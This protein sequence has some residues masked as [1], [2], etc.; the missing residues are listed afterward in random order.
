MFLDI[1]MW[2]NWANC[3][4]ERKSKCNWKLIR[5]LYRL[6]AEI[7]WRTIPHTYTR[8]NSIWQIIAIFFALVAD[9]WATVFRGIMNCEK[10]R[11]KQYKEPH[12]KKVN[13]KHSR[14]ELSDILYLNV[15]NGFAPSIHQKIQ[16]CHSCESMKYTESHIFHGLFWF[17]IKNNFELPLVASRAC[18]CHYSR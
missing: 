13:K 3:L 8:S 14:R 1:P 17:L 18:H 10:R 2:I 11:K 7:S 4:I 16:L 5:T 15:F 12:H 9:N 6:E